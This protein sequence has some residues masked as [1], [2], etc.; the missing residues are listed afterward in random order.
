MTRLFSGFAALAISAALLTVLCTSNRAILAAHAHGGCNAATLI[1]NYGLA[2][3]GFQQQ[4]NNSLPFYGAGVANF[5]GA[6]NMSATF[7]YSIAGT[8][9]T[10]N[11]YTGTYTV[12][13][14]CSV[15]VT[16][17]PG[18]GGDNFTGAVVRDGAEVLVTDISSPDTL[19]MILKRQ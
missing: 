3:S 8:S 11:P 13:S 19:N 10:N 4:Q 15:S 12:N 7:S 6:G 17:T 16:A 5:D 9:S 2:F 18:S 1:G 14:N